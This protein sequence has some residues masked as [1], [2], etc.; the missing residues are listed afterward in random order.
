MSELATAYVQIEPTAKGIQG[1]LT[2]ML[3]SE[4]DAAGNSSG[5]K[6][7]SAFG[8][9]AKA[10]LAAVGS[11]MAAA[12]GAVIKT[13]KEAIEGYADYEQLVGGIETLFGDS[14]DRVRRNA[15]EAYKT[16]GLSA[17]QYMETV[18]S[19]SASLLQSLGGDTE[20]AMQLADQAIRDMS[21]NANKMGTSMESIQNA[22]QSFA[23]GQYQL[24]DNLKLGY[25]GTKEEMQRLLEDATALSGIEYDISSYSDIINAIHTIQDNLGVTGTTAAEA[26]STISGSLAS[27]KAAFDNL[28]VSMANPDADVGV[29][30]DY[31]VES[32]ETALSNL[33]PVA[34]Q[35]LVGI[36]DVVGFLGPM[37]SEKLPGLVSTVLPSLLST[38][39]SLVNA[40]VGSLPSIIQVLV[41]QG[42]VII[43]SLVNDGILPNLGSIVAAG[44]DVL[45]ALASGI[46][47]SIPELIPTI[48]DVVLQIVNTL[49][50]PGTLGS[51]VDASIAI[52][53]GLANGLIAALPQLLAQAPVIIQ[54]LVTALVEN[55]PKLLEAGL[56][57]I[58]TLA[59][60]IL[61]NL[62]QIL[63]AAGEIVGT[64]I[65]GVLDLGGEILQIGV[66]I[67]SG[68]WEGI[69]SAGDWLWQ[70]IKGFF[71]DTLDAIC[72]FLGIHSPSTLFA[73][74]VGRNLALGVALGIEDNVGSVERAVGDMADAAVSAWNADQLS[75]D[76]AVRGSYSIGGAGGQFSGSLGPTEQAKIVS[77]V[78]AVGNM[79][80]AAIREKGFGISLDGETFARKLLP[81]SQAE[82]QRV[83]AAMVT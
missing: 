23:K 76:L 77:T 70:Q 81:Y 25:G 79:I 67:V 37:I 13:A 9:V 33:I 3:D 78:L 43:M 16:A 47:E 52:I 48:V 61:S 15:E 36:A 1:K 31:F 58:V 5:G 74:T 26:G 4:A 71:S 19:F 18:T 53:I 34:E 64:V 75:T 30:F 83:G 82:A 55:A 54:N 24:L 27:A 56:Q 59:D 45:V 72:E 38:A 8:A 41:A 14:A 68:I 11:A 42:P 62:G 57:V 80:V 40:L 66:D 2:N 20:E 6:F 65:Q 49:T 44:L 63:S 17:N 29:S 60:S 32:A 69:K 7:S 35:A 12:S 22:Y 39:T 28:L 51:L 50:D 73:D 10:G 21:D 46:A